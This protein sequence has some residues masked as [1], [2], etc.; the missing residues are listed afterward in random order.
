MLDYKPNM[1][2]SGASG[3]SRAMPEEVAAKTL[4]CL[5]RVVPAAIPGI[6]FLSGGQSDDEATV[7]LDAI[8]KR[9]TNLGAPWQLSFSYGRGLQQAALK[10]WSGK[11]G[12]VQQAKKAFYHRARLTSAARQGNYTPDMEMEPSPA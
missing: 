11:E 9:A 12:N 10:V 6:V 5:K 1:V 8:N 7:N 2:L 4:D 3:L